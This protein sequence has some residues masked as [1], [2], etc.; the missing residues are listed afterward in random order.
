MVLR[1]SWAAEGVVLIF[2]RRRAAREDDADGPQRAD[3]LGK[4]SGGAPRPSG[5]MVVVLRG[6]G[7]AEWVVL[8]FWRGRAT[9]VG[10]G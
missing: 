9:G 2:W 3:G 10:G 8:I 7:A 6:G 5:R 4:D 1:V